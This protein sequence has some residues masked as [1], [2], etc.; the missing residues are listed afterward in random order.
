MKNRPVNCNVKLLLR[1]LTALNVLLVSSLL[2]AIEEE[3]AI[4]TFITNTVIDEPPINIAKSVNLDTKHGDVSVKLTNIKTFE[5]Y[6]NISNKICRGDTLAAIEGNNFENDEEIHQSF[7]RS[8]NYLFKKL[9]QSKKCNYAKIHLPDEG[10]VA[11]DESY[12]WANA[13]YAIILSYYESDFV[14]QCY[15]LIRPR[16]DKT[17]PEIYEKFDEMFDELSSPLP[18]NWR[19]LFEEQSSNSAVDKN[20]VSNLDITN[21][22]KRVNQIDSI[23]GYKKHK[24]KWF[25]SIIIMVIFM[26]ILIYRFCIRRKTQ[27]F[28][29]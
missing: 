14:S 17:D 29:E 9:G 1:V 10:D 4:N 26:V 24:Y 20:G 11:N 22:A 25:M 23:A 8:K 21:A 7:L 15:L 27:D 2:Q 19:T 13:K 18:D 5:R 6:A 16:E 12:S 3:M 28:S